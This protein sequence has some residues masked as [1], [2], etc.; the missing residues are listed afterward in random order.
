MST[1]NFIRVNKFIF[2]K[3]IKKLYF[4]VNGKKDEIKFFDFQTLILEK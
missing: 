1:P 2:E 3:K 4:L